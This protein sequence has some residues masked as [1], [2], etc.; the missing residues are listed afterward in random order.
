MRKTFDINDE[1]W[2]DDLAEPESE[3][4]AAFKET[5]EAKV[6]L[7][8][9]KRKFTS[10]NPKKRPKISKHLRTYTFANK[11]HFRKLLTC[12]RR[13]CLTANE[14]SLLQQQIS[15]S[16]SICG[17]TYPLTN[18]TSANCWLAVCRI[19]WLQTKIHFRNS[20][21]A[22]VCGLTYPLTNCTSANCG[23]AE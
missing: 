1:D 22:S 5:T 16:A 12:G 13:N 21:S 4:F 20:K 17:L 10:P 2:V 9:W 18:C 6:T 19:A 15:K 3:I 8:H 14:N 7:S 11:L 23:L